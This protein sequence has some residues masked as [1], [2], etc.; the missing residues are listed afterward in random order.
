L[1]YQRQGQWE[2]AR[3]EFTAALQAC[4]AAENAGSERAAV[5]GVRSACQAALKNSG[6]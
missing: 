3:R 2:N 4:D 5:G 6:S 1:E